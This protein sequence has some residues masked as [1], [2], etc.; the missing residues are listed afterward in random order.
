MLFALLGIMGYV[1]FR[2]KHWDFGIA[3]VLALLH[4]VLFAMGALVLLGRQIDLL[5]VTGLLTI[6]GYSINDTIVIY[7][8]VRENMLAQGR[9]MSLTDV[10]NL[11]VNQSLARTLITSLTT[12]IIVFSFFFL[13][14]EVLNT[15]SLTLLIGLVVGTYSSMFI[16]SPIVVWVQ[17][18]MKKS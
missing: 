8:R 6:A 18:F 1:G 10:I 13:G 15:F 7:D 4:D 9:K 12:L 5:V 14:G 3:G 11:S 17:R 16:V 2:F